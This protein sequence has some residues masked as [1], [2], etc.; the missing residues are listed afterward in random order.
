MCRNYA[1]LR[2]KATEALQETDG[3]LETDGEALN[4]TSEVK[5]NLKLNYNGMIVT[6]KHSF[7]T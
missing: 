1:S 4:G 3:H 7:C 5:Y 6:G 2:G